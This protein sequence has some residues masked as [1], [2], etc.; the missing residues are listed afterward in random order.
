MKISVLIPT[1]NEPLINDL[2]E[3]IHQVLRNYNHEI[4]II[5]KS[6]TS[7][8]I[9]NAKLILQKSDGLGKAVLE[10]L[11][12]ASG[13]III[14]MDGDFSHNP[15]DIIKLLDVSKNVDIVAGSRFIE[16][17]KSLDITHRKFISKL[18]RL[19]VHL[20]LDITVKDSMS[21]FVAIKRKV[22][23]KIKLNPIGY[24]INMEI[25]YKSKKFGFKIKEIPIV[26][27]KR[28][29]GRSKAG[30]REGFRTLIFILRISSNS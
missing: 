6:D 22:Y 2:I 11:E 28:K 26:F 3:N 24:K 13:D 21:G 1:K 19:I 23:D 9:K 29:Y 27:Q 30:I 12:H 18:F 17:G 4:I 20:I 5:D 10:G 15:K 25:F 14:T 16:R 8:Q 7:P